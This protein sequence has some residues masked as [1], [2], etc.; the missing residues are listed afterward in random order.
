MSLTSLA[1][2]TIHAVTRPGTSRRHAPAC[3]TAV[4]KL[5][6]YNTVP[7]IAVPTQTYPWS[8]HP[9]RKACV[10]WV[11]QR[12]SLRASRFNAV[13]DGTSE[14]TIEHLDEL[15]SNTSKLLKLLKLNAYVELVGCIAVLLNPDAVFPAI[16]QSTSGTECAQ[17]YALALACVALASYLCSRSLKESSDELTQKKLKTIALPTTSSML[18]YHAGVSLFQVR[19][20]FFTQF[21]LVACGALSVHAPLAVCFATAT[22]FCVCEEKGK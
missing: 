14:T 1:F 21:S 20:I 8:H 10:P 2:V 7:T 19:Q 3:T 17:W 4:S 16:S 5:A 18:L 6:R 11:A 15:N 13:V 12:H 22:T 9:E